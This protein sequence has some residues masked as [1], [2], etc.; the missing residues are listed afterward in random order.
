MSATFTPSSDNY[1]KFIVE[2]LKPF[3][4]STYSTLTDKKIP[5]SPVLAWVD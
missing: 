2:E 4:D 5:S 3:I 1:L